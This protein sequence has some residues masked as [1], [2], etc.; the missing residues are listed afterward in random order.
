MP[1]TH[2]LDIRSTKKGEPP[3]LVAPQLIEAIQARIDR[4]EQSIIFLNRRGYSSSLQ[5]PQCGHVEMCP[6]CSVALTFH[7]QA[8]RLRC[9]LC[10]FASNVPHA[11]PL[12][13]ALPLIN[14]RVAVRKNWSMPWRM[15]SPMRELREWIP[16]V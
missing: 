13:A 15:P 9:H 5:C 2:I 8:A 6:N 4:Q 1:T 7:R 10:D 12:S 3:V 11:C 14:T 16:I